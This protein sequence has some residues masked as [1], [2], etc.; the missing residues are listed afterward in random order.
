MHNI[1]NV[2]KS[3]S[4]TM[5]KVHEKLDTRRLKHNVANF[6][7]TIEGHPNYSK[8]CFMKICRYV[9]IIKFSLKIDLII[10]LNLIM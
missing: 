9:M 7:V 3:N 6:E 2:K 4:W 8:T 1:S 5:D 10:Y